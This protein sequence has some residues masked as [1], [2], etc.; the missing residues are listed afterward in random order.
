MLI[1]AV[2]DYSSV[3]PVPTGSD[4]ALGPALLALLLPTVPPVV[5]ASAM[6]PVTHG[7]TATEP[8]LSFLAPPPPPPPPDPWDPPEV[9]PV[10]TIPPR[11]Q[12]LAVRAGYRTPIALFHSAEIEATEESFDAGSADVTV[13]AYDPAWALISDLKDVEWQVGYD[14]VL[15]WS[16]VSGPPIDTTGGRVRLPLAGPG[17]V[18][19]ET[20]LGEVEQRDFYGGAGRFNG[21]IAGWFK[22]DDPGDDFESTSILACRYAPG[23]GWEGSGALQVIG[24]GYIFGP[25]VTLPGHPGRIRNPQGSV[26]AKVPS[27]VVIVETQVKDGDDLYRY[28]V[29]QERAAVIEADTGWQ[30]PVGSVGNLPGG[31]GQV[32]IGLY[33]ESQDWCTI[34]FARIQWATLSGSTV[35]IDLSAYP[36]IVMRDAQSAEYGGARWG[37]SVAVDSLAN[38]S[39]RLVWGHADDH[40]IGSI[41]QTLSER[42]DGPDIW[43]D[44]YWTMHVAARRGRPRNDIVLNNTTV[45]APEWAEDV[46]ASIDELRVLTDFGSGATRVVS[47]HGSGGRAGRKIRQIV[48]AD[49]GQTLDGADR[50]GAGL[51]SRQSLPQRTATLR[52]PLALGRQLEVG[53]TLPV[54]LYDGYRGWNGWVRIFSIRKVYAQSV[55]EV[56][57]GVDN[58]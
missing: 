22:D 53:D 46:G 39:D 44:R 23:E 47:A 56:A 24:V 40:P 11:V 42:S 48:R 43:V 51:F 31:G 13:S 3:P 29:T 34:D 18:L 25:W 12:L 14:G 15:E 17:S 41:L 1:G 5:D 19:D 52:V 4:G 20:T 45:L 55:A 9:P 30:G 7:Q 26:M 36:G 37:I 10:L 57:V 49:K 38:S 28:E 2:P 27:G 54:A 33:V 16:G 50:W 32:R 8:L 35:P 58:S 6:A 21:G